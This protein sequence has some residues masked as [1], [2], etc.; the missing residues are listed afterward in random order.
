VLKRDLRV[1]DLTAI[2]LCRE[3]SLPIIV[4]NMHVPHNLKRLVMG[5]EVG[6]LVS[7]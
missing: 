1:M 6:S 7:E 4:F 3:N 5:E 2:T